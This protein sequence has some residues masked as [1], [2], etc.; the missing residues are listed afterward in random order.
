MMRKNSMKIVAL[1][2]A[3]GLI[4]SMVPT[5][6]AMA[7][8]EA[9][10][11]IGSTYSTAEGYVNEML[12]KNYTN[13]SRSFKAGLYTGEDVLFQVADRITELGTAEV[14]QE[15]R[16]YSH[17][18][19]VVD[20]ELGDTIK[21]T[22]DVPETAQY[23]FGF[24]YLAYNDSVLPVG[25]A[26]KVDGEFPYYECRNLE[27][28]STWVGKEEKSYDRYDNEIVTV[29]DKLFQWERKYL[30]DGSYRYSLPLNLELTAGTHEIEMSMLEGAFLLG[31]VVLSAPE[32]I[33]E[34]TGSQVAGGTQMIEIQGEDFDYR[35]DSAIHA[36]AEYD[37]SLEPYEVTDTVLNTID[38]DSFAN[39]GQKVTYEFEVTEAG[40]YYIAAN[41][42]QSDKQDF[43]VF[44]NV[45]IDGEI[46]NSEFVSYP[47]EYSTK[48]R[49]VTLS[50]DEGQYLSVYLEEGTHTISF[51]IS[52]D[53]IR[54]ILEGLDEIMSHINDLSLEITKVAGTNADKYRDLKLSKYIPDIEDQ[55]YG[56]AQELYDLQETVRCHVG[57]S[58]DSI[59]ILSSMSIAAEMLISLAEEPDE[60]PYRVAELCTSVSSANRHLANTVDKLIENNL[61]IDR[62]WI[63]QADAELPKK[64]GVFQSAWMNIKRFVSSFTDQAYSTNNT[65]PEHLQVWVNR[66]SQ[67]VQIMQKMIDEYFTPQ[68]GIEVDISIMPDQ[69]KLVLANSAG[70]APDVA[71]G[72]NYT[73]PYEL[74]IRGALVDM[75]EFEDFQEVAAPY[76][77]GFFMTATI[78]DSVY[79]MPE[80]MNFWVLFYR[81]DILDKLGL[82]VPNTMQDVIDMLPELQMRGLNYYQPVS[83]MRVMRN[84][85]GTT[86]LIHQFGGSLYN[87]T[88]QEGTG[89]GSAE[90]IEG[91][92]YLTELFTIYNLPID[93]D[94]FY[95][96]FRNGDMPLGVADYA[97]YNLMT[98]AAPEL[99]NSWEIALVPGVEQ[100]DGSIAR[101][102]CGNAESCVIF[103]SDSEREQK[104]WEFIRW[105]SSSEV[106]A[107]FG[108]TLQ[109]TYGSEYMWTTANMEAF[110]EL[111][112]DSQD[113]LIIREQMSEVVDVARVPGTYLLEREISNA[114]NDIVVNKQTAQMRI[115]E[116]VKTID[117]EIDRKL[118]EF[119]YIDSEGNTTAEYRVPTV[120][121]IRE[122]LGRTAE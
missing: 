40:Y 39:A 56:Y 9:A 73:V 62:I 103:K 24:D 69:Y 92:T 30:S 42:R 5:G 116:A 108:Q 32:V 94:N 93:I 3:A 83:G 10:G 70:N 95:Q 28:E 64:P 14:T 52:I 99:N 49:T 46:P 79:A 34:Y 118:E 67:Y 26:F 12:T 90:S 84:F 121:S 112:W 25:L 88:A 54:H 20:M 96:H 100:E 37:T 117:R 38:S 47:M 61:A 60:I 4:C 63:Y 77:E 113:K 27:F 35:N 85:H 33:E 122:L 105:W 75:T 98:N 50:D 89:F 45:E 29:P 65:D 13:V 11:D 16:E 106:Q 51:T 71:T 43:P 8:T 48:Y 97:T 87:E 81:S 66:S 18:A 102:T 22:V 59:A 53:N 72:V 119:E 114:F 44:V 104:A 82:E 111:P 91:F 115:D 58:K 15:T 1:S 6:T 101:T 7:E 68:T 74:A 110:M 19:S 41:Y 57:D 109:I 80:T 21:F 36:V 120:E 2:V 76:E 31:G 86:P 107:E 78:N 55:L 17:A 23:Y